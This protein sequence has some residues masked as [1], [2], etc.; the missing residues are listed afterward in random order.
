MPPKTRP[1]HKITK[2][3]TRASSRTSTIKSSNASSYAALTKAIA[4][5]TP[6]KSPSPPK[7]GTEPENE[8]EPAANTK[9]PSAP[10][11]FWRPHDFNGYLG[12]WYKSEWE[13]EGD[14]YLTAEMW[15]M[16]GKARL[17]GDEKI[18]Q[19]MLATPNPKTCKSLGRQV[20]NFDDK[21]WNRERERIVEEGNYLKFTKSNEAA[22]LRRLLLE[23]GERELVEASPMDRIWGVGFGEKNAGKNRHRWGL[24]LLGVVLMRVRERLREE[25]GKEGKNEE[26]GRE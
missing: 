2:T 24:N 14:T 16:V 13:H 19:A 8:T 25:G 21:V 5:K 4:S 26:E 17:F 1:P 11:Y 10:V 3:P 7:T 20:A 22:E 23:T 12:Q 18:A 6:H 15:M 9:D